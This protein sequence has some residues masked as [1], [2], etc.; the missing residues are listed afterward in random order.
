MNAAAAATF[1]LP[2]QSASGYGELGVH[3][4]ILSGRLTSLNTNMMDSFAKEITRNGNRT[5][6]DFFLFG[7]SCLF[8]DLPSENAKAEAEQ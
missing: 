5:I 4:S 6:M 3:I 8:Y 1:L 2:M 7:W